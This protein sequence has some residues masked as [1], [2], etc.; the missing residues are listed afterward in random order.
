MT[1]APAFASDAAVEAAYPL[2]PMQQGMLFHAFEQRSEG[3]YS[4]QI[5]CGLAGSLDVDRFRRAWQGAVDRHEVLRTVFPHPGRGV[6][7]VLSTAKV[8]FQYEDWSAMG[9]SERHRRLDA[10]GDE[11]STVDRWTVGQAT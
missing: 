2:S 6:Q 1:E 10:G 4:A 3:L 5:H 7:V 8:P 9:T 11:A